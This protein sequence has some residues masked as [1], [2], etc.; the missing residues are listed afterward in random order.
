MNIKAPNRKQLRML[1][2]ACACAVV[3]LSTSASAHPWLDVDQANPGQVYKAKLH[4]PH[5]CDTAPTIAL[6][7][8]TPEGVDAVEAV[9]GGGWKA[10][11][12]KKGSVY[13]ITYEGGEVAWD[14]DGQFEFSMRISDLKP[15]RLYIPVIQKCKG[16]DSN[17]WIE[18]PANGKSEHELDWP[19]AMLDV[20]TGEIKGSPS[21]APQ[22]GAMGA[23]AHHH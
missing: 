8:R 21:A 13:E 16:G 20:V 7:V 4:I 18:T 19:A 9:S 23:D 22:H 5:G 3:A 2:A 1:G 11:A 12:V 6:V 15:T 10:T 14:Q 17:R